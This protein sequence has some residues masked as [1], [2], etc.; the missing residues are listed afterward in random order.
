MDAAT[1]LSSPEMTR[2]YRLGHPACPDEWEIYYRIRRDVLL[3]AR[4]YAV[5]LDDE[6]APDHHPHLLWLDTQPIGTIRVDRVPPDRAAM[7]LVAI[8]PACQ[9]QGHGRALLQLAEEF[10]RRLGCGKAV[11]YATPEAAGFYS[12]VGYAEEDWDDVYVSGIVQMAKPL[13]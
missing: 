1:A 4:K 13:G 7:R 6:L 5:E 8:D 9:G 3:E 2:P 12:K 10:A 11:V